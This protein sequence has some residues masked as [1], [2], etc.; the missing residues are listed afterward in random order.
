VERV[1]RRRRAVYGS[2]ASGS[3]NGRAV[4]FTSTTG[5]RSLSTT[6]NYTVTSSVAV[7]YHHWIRGP[8]A[9]DDGDKLFPMCVQRKY[10]LR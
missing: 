5:S 4:H 6:V 9:D 2:S 7:V 10:L 3:R 8:S 1:A